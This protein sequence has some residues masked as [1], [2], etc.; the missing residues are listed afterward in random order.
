[1]CL[2]F[3]VEEARDEGVEVN[4]QNGQ[5]EADDFLEESRYTTAS[6]ATAAE[7]D[8]SEVRNLFLTL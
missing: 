5:D 2:L 7:N 4:G 3:C 8:V 6:C 1:M